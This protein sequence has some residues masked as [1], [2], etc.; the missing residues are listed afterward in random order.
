MVSSAGCGGIK[1]DGIWIGNDGICIGNDG[2]CIENDGICIENMEFALKMMEFGLQVVVL[3]ACLRA[4]I[5]RRMSIATIRSSARYHKMMGVTLNK[6]DFGFKMMAFVLQMMNSLLKMLEL[7]LQC[8]VF[9]QD[10]IKDDRICIQNAQFLS[11]RT[12]PRATS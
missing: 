8:A 2:I 1:N 9:C 5:T 12:P 11:V 6:L 3:F 4:Q 10:S 7:A